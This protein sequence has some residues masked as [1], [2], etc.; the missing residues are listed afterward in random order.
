[1][2]DNREP[3]LPQSSSRRPQSNP[4]LRLPHLPSDLS[5]PRYAHTSHRPTVHPDRSSF[6]F[7]RRGGAAGERKGPQR[8]QEQ[9]RRP[10]TVSQPPPLFHSSTSI[11][12][13]PLL[14][15]A[16]AAAALLPGANAELEACL[17]ALGQLT[18]APYSYALPFL[19]GGTGTLF[20]GQCSA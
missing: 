15:L 4:K 5:I 2:P 1:M 19:N 14:L 11:I 18:T 6:A 8:A 3:S 16:V 13:K 17:A 10:T 12:M 7:G 9:E 20:M